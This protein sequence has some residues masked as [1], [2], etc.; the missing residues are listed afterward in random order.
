MNSLLDQ[1]YRSVLNELSALKTYRIKPASVLKTKEYVVP[2]EFTLEERN[3]DL[4]SSKEARIIIEPS[5][6][7]ESGILVGYGI[8]IEDLDNRRINHIGGITKNGKY[9]E[10]FGIAKSENSSD[11]AGKKINYNVCIYTNAIVNISVV[12]E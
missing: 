6:P 3:G 8:D 12:Y 1:E 9:E 10:Q 2:I 11:T 7:T 5:D 4:H